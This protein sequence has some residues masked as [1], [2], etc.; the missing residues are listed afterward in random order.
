M[1][2]SC[3]TQQQHATLARNCRL[4]RILPGASVVTRISDLVPKVKAGV[5][6]RECFSG[7]YAEG[8]VTA[9][10][11]VSVIRAQGLPHNK[12]HVPPL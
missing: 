9:Q 11:P 7:S 2:D 10:T 12:I 3:N 8:A 5:E 4:S 6:C 1:R